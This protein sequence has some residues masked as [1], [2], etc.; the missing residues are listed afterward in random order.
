MSALVAWLAL[1]FIVYTYFGFPLYLWFRARL[2]RI[3]EPVLDR[4]DWPAVTVV[5]S[6]YNEAKAIET[7]LNSLAALD[8]PADK[9]R[10]V[11]V[12]DG[13]EDETVALANAL[14]LRWLTVVTLKENSG[15][16]VAI[17][18]AMQHVDTEFC[19]FMDARQR[20][21]AN[22]LKAL[23]AHF[24][25]TQIGAVSGELMIVDE[26]NPEQVNMGLYW[27]YEK[28]LRE[29]ESRLYSTAGA[30][31]A[32]YAVRTALFKPLPDDAILDDFDTPVNVLQAGKRVIFEPSA[33]VFD[34]SQSSLQDE[35]KRKLRTLT[36][37]FQ[38]FA[39]HPW[40]FNPMRNPIWWQFLSHK[41]F[42]LVVPWCL[43][44]LLPASAL[45]GGAWW[46]LVLVGQLCFYALALSAGYVDF[47][48]E[49]KISS[50]AQTFVQLNLAAWLAAYRYYKGD[51]SA[52][53]KS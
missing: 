21:S 35:F 9:W 36:G 45:A 46:T 3:P 22:A 25:D 4:N 30:T 11:L 49:N 47:F 5:I 6:A 17:N 43:L 8:Y 24:D 37:N 18:A 7:K 52:R 19:V 14:E 51:V 40:L 15:K 26:E 23:L 32:L 31:G 20:V 28:A 34:T 44:L 38:S 41:V 10:A 1:I 42:R 13:S 50:F 53:W 29:M 2:L 39:Q 48:R 12:D 33:Q 27:R 16:P